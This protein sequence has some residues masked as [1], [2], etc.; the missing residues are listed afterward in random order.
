MSTKYF[1]TNKRAKAFQQPTFYASYA[2]GRKQMH[3]SSSVDLFGSITLKQV[4]YSS[5]KDD[6]GNFVADGVNTTVLQDSQDA[7]VIESKFECPSI[8]LHDMDVASLG[9]AS[10]LGREALY[11]R[12][13][14][15]GYGQPPTGSAGIF[16][17]LRESAV[18][19]QSSAFLNPDA[20][21]FLTGSLIDICGFEASKE[22][23]GEI[24]SSREISEAVVAIPMNSNGEF[25]NIDPAMF[26]QQLVNVNNGDPAIKQGQ[27]EAPSDITETSISHMIKMMKKYI[28]PPQFDP[29]KNAS[30]SPVVM[31][32]FE[33]THTLSKT[34]LSYIWQNLM[35]DIAMKAEKDSSII[36]HDVRSK[37]EFF[38][39]TGYGN[40][41]FKS[42]S[43]DIKWMVFKVK[44]RGKNNYFN[45]TKKSE[46][47]LGF[48]FTT[49][50]E[51][52]QF[53]SVPNKELNYSY[54]WPYD[55]FSLVELAQLEV[56]VD[57]TPK[58]ISQNAAQLAAL[59]QAGGNSAATAQDSDAPV[60]ATTQIT[61]GSESTSTMGTDTVGKSTTDID[62]IGAL[63]PF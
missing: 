13:L 55:F 20:P 39:S 30:A 50:A 42:S 37:Y 25:Y 11:T 2:A 8:N 17:Q 23:V 57:I 36:Q 61:D 31:Y 54:N 15:K 41:P 56:G 16:L 58:P 60:G 3:I 6:E 29:I 63:K 47:A 10:G 7:W 33:F 59:A 52:A 51:L 12:G 5:K 32:I 43:S 19:R 48:P 21:V 44:K 49:D 62:S 22:R 18:Q 14:W 9:A 46:K 24:A 1:N 53:S 35:P 4:E 40:S 28:V 38:G 45:V 34:D 26:L 27:F